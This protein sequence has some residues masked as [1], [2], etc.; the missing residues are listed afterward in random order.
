MAKV[1][2]QDGD[3]IKEWEVNMTPDELEGR[4]NAQPYEL[5][6]TEGAT[7]VALVSPTVAEMLQAGQIAKE[8][9]E[10]DEKGDEDEGVVDDEKVKKLLAL[11]EEG[12]EE[13]ED[14]DEDEDTEKQAEIL[15]MIKSLTEAVNALMKEVAELKRGGEV[16]KERKQ[17]TIIP[18]SQAYE[19]VAKFEKEASE[20][21]ET[22]E[23]AQ[24]NLTPF[25]QALLREWGI[26]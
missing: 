21:D 22:N 16:S 2:F 13:S 4:L 12:E 3:L 15:E 7:I 24:G 9:K 26:L 18:P 8:A 25:Q 17:V 1:I 11:L 6:T 10:D 14:E 20:K 23:G 19:R 5:Q